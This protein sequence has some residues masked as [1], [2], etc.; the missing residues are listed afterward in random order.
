[1]PPGTILHSPM[2]P[3]V[4]KE[5]STMPAVP[6]SSQTM[7]L[8]VSSSA[9]TSNAQDTPMST[10]VSSSVNTVPVQAVA[11][12]TQLN[13]AATNGNTSAASIPFNPVYNFSMMGGYC[14][15]SPAMPYPV[16][17]DSTLQRPGRQ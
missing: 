5:L 15:P 13:Q 12:S 1:M 3:P 11:E 6:Q 17:C 4:P 14:I 9:Q 16:Q 7:P 8:P 2:Q 10:N